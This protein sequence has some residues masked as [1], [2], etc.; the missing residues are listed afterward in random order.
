[1]TKEEQEA[2]EREYLQLLEETGELDEVYD[3]LVD[4][5]EISM[6]DSAM[7]GVTQGASFGFVDE[8]SGGFE[9]LGRKAGVAGLGE[10]FDDWRSATEEEQAQDFAEIYAQARDKRRAE[11]D[12]AYEANPK[13]F[14]AADAATSALIPGT[15]LKALTKA[16][17][18]S[19]LGHSEADNVGGM[20]QD[21]ALGGGLGYAGGKVGKWI[22][23]KMAS[24]GQQYA[25][26]AKDSA[27]KSMQATPGEIAKKNLLV[28]SKQYDEAAEMLLE[29]GSGKP[30]IV[31]SRATSQDM[32]DRVKA[33]EKAAKDKLDTIYASQSDEIFVEDVSDL[34]WN[35]AA[36]LEL[37]GGQ[38]KEADFVAKY[39]TELNRSYSPDD[40]LNAQD[41]RN[42]INRIKFD[43]NSKA[44]KQQADTETRNVL[45][46]IRNGLVEKNSDDFATANRQSTTA[47]KLRE[48]LEKRAAKDVTNT[49]GLSSAVEGAAW[50]TSLSA[51]EDAD[52]GVPASA[53]LALRGVNLWKKHGNRFKSVGLNKASKVLKNKKYQSVLTKAAER[54]TK[55]LQATHFLLMQQDPKYRE[56]VNSDK[57]EQE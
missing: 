26:E 36:K 42:L 29:G 33:I 23:G 16:G 21:T 14:L 40:I 27:I 34:L 39:V 47:I 53:L 10:G 45:T 9:A 2:I 50:A 7:A 3:D 32:F 51:A 18:A 15:S 17:L 41:L 8:L 4:E 55:A 48:I 1:M 54:G 11:Q 57:K 19:G 25:D 28:G 44:T 12:A 20:V 35:R 46:E 5:N 38:T 24:K 6:G 56:S 52:L 37:T 30:A 22:G 43:P 13:T 31:S 49:G